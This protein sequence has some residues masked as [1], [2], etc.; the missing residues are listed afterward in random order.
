MR[1]LWLERRLGSA[2]I[3]REEER[4]ADTKMRINRD[5]FYMSFS[6]KL[7]PGLRLNTK[8]GLIEGGGQEEEHSWESNTINDTAACRRDSSFS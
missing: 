4:L 5:C 3:L 6:Q 1:G 8:Q 7:Y 2:I